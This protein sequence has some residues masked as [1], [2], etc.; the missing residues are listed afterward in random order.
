GRRKGEP[1]FFADAAVHQGPNYLA[2]RGARCDRSIVDGSRILHAST[3]SRAGR[4]ELVQH[5]TR[6][7]NGVDA[8]HPASQRWYN[9]SFLGGHIHGR[10]WKIH[11]PPSQRV[12]VAATGSHL[13]KPEHQ[14]DISGRM[15]RFCPGS[16]TDIESA[17]KALAA[18]NHRY[19]EVLSKLL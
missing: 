5:S 14:R 1:L 4:L 15:D 16:Q 11:A 13:E 6:R 9:G 3:L 18:R 17:H 19:S 2:R 10:S 12:H 8:F 7:W